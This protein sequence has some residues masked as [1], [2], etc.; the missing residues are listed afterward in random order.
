VDVVTHANTAAN[1]KEMR[2]V[3][4][5][6]PQGPP[7]NIFTENKGR[8]LAKRTFTDRLSIGK[9]ADQVDLYYFGRGHTNGDAWIVFPS[10]RMMHAG[11]IF[12]GKFVPLLDSN[13]GG[14]GV[15]IA[16]TLAKAA[17]L[18]GVDSIITGHSTV[19][20]PNDLKEFAEFNRDFATAARDAKRAGRSVDEVA[21]SWTV[22]AK[23]AGYSA[24]QAVR[25]RANIE[26]AYKELP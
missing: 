2:A 1:M 4:G 3:T 23:Y 21:A 12:S 11:D 5:V 19:M 10:L 6:Q 22:P 20:T 7:T 24:P 8:G 26:L 9:G 25:L 13:N 16:D 15:E 18:Q 14:S 17:R